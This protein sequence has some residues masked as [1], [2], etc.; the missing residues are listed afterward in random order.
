MGTLTLEEP[1]CAVP[2]GLILKAAVGGGTERVG[3]IN[4]S[5]L[6]KLEFCPRKVS[7]GLL[8]LREEAELALEGEMDSGLLA[9]IGV[10]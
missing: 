3:V 1:V 4:E 8:G 6:T 10:S 7:A 9:F 2:N 5:K